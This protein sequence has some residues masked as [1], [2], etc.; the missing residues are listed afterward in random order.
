[1]PDVETV[2]HAEG[3]ST[4]EIEALAI[5]SLLES[6]GIPVVMVGDPVLPNLPFEIKVASE[7][8]ARARQV[9]SEAESGRPRRRG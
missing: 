5:K 9:I 2:F 6:N 7:D 8:A 4:A 3:S 1:M